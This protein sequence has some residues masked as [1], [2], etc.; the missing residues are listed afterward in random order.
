MDLIAFCLEFDPT[1][2]SL[3]PLKDQNRSQEGF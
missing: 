1:Q 2:S 3:K